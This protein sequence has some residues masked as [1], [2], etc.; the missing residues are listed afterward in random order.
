MKTKIS[1]ADVMRRAWAIFRN[2]TRSYYCH[3]NRMFYNFDNFSDCLKRAWA[4]EKAS[5]KSNIAKIEEQKKREALALHRKNRDVSSFGMNMLHNSLA[6]YYAN[7][8]FNGD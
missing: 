7:S 2:P 1:R 8:R 4:V 5:V 3:S 6:N